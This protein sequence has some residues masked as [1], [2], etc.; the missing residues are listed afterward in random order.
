MTVTAATGIEGARFVVMFAPV[1]P[2]EHDVAPSA[3][4]SVLGSGSNGSSEHA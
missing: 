3:V 4:A 1:R 2:P